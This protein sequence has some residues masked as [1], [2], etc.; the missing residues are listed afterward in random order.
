MKNSHKLSDAVHILAY[1]DICKNE[2][3]SSNAIASSVESNPSLI[4][5][6]MSQLNQAGLLITHAGKVAPELAKEPADISLLDVYQA[7]DE[8]NNLLHI[9][10]KTNPRCIV[11]GNIQDTLNLAYQKVQNAAENQ[12]NDITLQDIIEDILVRDAQKNSRS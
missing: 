10:E 8:D 9:D 11:G 12:M 4:R 2:D 5:R 6:L 3:L 1:I 7:L